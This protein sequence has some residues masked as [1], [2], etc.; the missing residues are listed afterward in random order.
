VTVSRP[1]RSDAI[2]S[3]LPNQTFGL[4]P[5]FSVSRRSWRTRPGP[6]LYDANV[7]ERFV[8]VVHRLIFEELIPHEPHVFHPA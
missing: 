4:S 2:C 5:R 6:A 3:T 7:K 1:I 8:Q